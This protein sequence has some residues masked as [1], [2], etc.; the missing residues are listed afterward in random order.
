MPLAMILTE[1]SVPPEES[2][3]ASIRLL[4]WPSFQTQTNTAAPLALT[5]MT[6]LLTPAGES[7]RVGPKAPPA[8][9]V[10]ANT[11]YLFWLSWP[12]QLKKALPLLS[13]AMCGYASTEKL[14]P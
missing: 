3:R 7:D 9:R 12:V 5:A 8:V 2:C 4:P 6:E 11:R 14:P 1:P 13:T 10:R